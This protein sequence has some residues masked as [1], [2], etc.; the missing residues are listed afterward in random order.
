MKKVTALLV[1]GILMLSLLTAC[2]GDA[3]K[4]SSDGKLKI[5]ATVFPAYDWVRQ[6]IGDDGGE[7]ELTLLLGNG[8][9]LHSYQPTANDII[10]MTTC[11]MFI[12]VGG[13]SDEW[14]EEALEQ[15]KNPDMI[16]INLLEALGEGAK[17]E[18]TIEG[19]QI[20]YEEYDEDQ[21]EIEL[22]EHVWLSLRNAQQL[23]GVISQSLGLLEPSE[24]LHFAANA[25][26]YNNSLSELD[27]R[28][29]QTVASSPL[30]TLVFCD[31]FPFRYLV[32]DYNLNYFA[33]FNGCSSETD[34]SFETVV[35]LAN[36]ADELELECVIALET[37]NQAL[38]KTVVENT[39]NKT[40]QVLVLDSMQSV[41]TA[42]I[43]NGASYLGIMEENLEVLRQALS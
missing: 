27:E 23:C 40:A 32:D 6:I 28:F 31:R 7:I 34:A 10:E 4:N 30:D 33:A 2:S 3:A 21:E 18:E 29:A 17:I 36:K 24:A 16:V 20:E 14:V 13:E 5:V 22:D 38:A 39:E 26:D 25:E 15:S 35:F 37:S 1:A 11:D 19:M 41:T 42:R 43:D 8:V 12:Y 9:D